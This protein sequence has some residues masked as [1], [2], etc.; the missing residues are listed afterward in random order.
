MPKALRLS[1]KQVM[2][3]LKEM[4]TAQNVKVYKRHGAG[5]ILYGVSFANLRKLARKIKTDHELA[6]KLWDTGNF[7]ARNLATM[8]VDVEIFSQDEAESWL[9]D[10]NA[11]L[12]ADLVAEI[13]SKT[14]YGLDL[15]LD[16]MTSDK[17]YR[18]QCGYSILCSVLKNGTKISDAQCKKFLKVIEKEIHQSPNRA[19]HSM[20]MSLIAIGIYKPDLT[21]LAIDYAKKIGKVVVDHGETSCTTPD[22]IPYIKKAVTRRS[23]KS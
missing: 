2:N 12:L 14:S 8:I 7:D 9:S 21:E 15:M 11:Y 6:L 18:K 16:W 22:A 4:G 13:I 1:L 20:N 17:E 5:D 3:D 10:I 23:K 19:K